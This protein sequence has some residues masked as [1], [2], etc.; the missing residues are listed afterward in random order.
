M[1]DSKILNIKRFR[2]AENFERTFLS[3]EIGK[4]IMRHKNRRIARAS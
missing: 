2:Y 1:R 4:Q 3:E